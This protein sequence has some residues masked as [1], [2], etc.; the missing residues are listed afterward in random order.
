MKR[1]SRGLIVGFLIVASACIGC[2]KQATSSPAPAPTLKTMVVGVASWYGHPFDGRQ[3][4]NGEIYDMEKLTAAHRTYAFGTVLLVR[5]QSNGRT[6]QVRINDRGPF[7]V[8]RII[9]LSHQ[10][11][12]EIAMPSIAHVALEIVSVPKKRGLQ[13]YAVQIGSFARQTDARALASRMQNQFGAARVIFRPGDETWRVLVGAFTN[14][15]DANALAGQLT[16]P[17][18]PAFVILAEEEQQ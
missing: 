10:A 5:N 15:E 12:Q 3:T 2:S 18:A 14:I 16:R 17:E 7:V 9:D 13:E 4:A 8:D 11:A 1:T 6:V